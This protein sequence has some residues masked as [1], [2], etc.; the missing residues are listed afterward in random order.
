MACKRKR[1]PFP[2]AHRQCDGCSHHGWDSGRKGKSLRQ[3]CS[4][5]LF[6]KPGRTGAV[7]PPLLACLVPSLHPSLSSLA[8]FLLPIDI[9][10]F[11]PNFQLPAY[12]NWL[13]SSSNESA[14][15]KVMVDILV[16]KANG[17]FLIFIFLDLCE[18]AD[19][20]T[21]LVSLKL[22]LSLLRFW[23]WLCPRNLTFNMP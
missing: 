23:A 16:N 12:C 7:L 17:Y 15:P 11:P 14:L 22:S 19:M 9:N 2:H 1:S 4:F 21:L 3:R 10:A 18:T 13:P 6:R 5:S 8:A 20:L